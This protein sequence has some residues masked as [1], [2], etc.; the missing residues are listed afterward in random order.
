MLKIPIKKIGKFFLEKFG[1]KKKHRTFASAFIEKG[2][3][4]KE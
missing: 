2:S 1:D 4:E 3:V